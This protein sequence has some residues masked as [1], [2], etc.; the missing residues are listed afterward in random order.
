M[1]EQVSFKIVITQKDLDHW[2]FNKK[3]NRESA[4][5][6]FSHILSKNWNFPKEDIEHYFSI[7]EQK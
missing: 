2:N 5:E 6:V 1:T 3:L 7:E 4:I